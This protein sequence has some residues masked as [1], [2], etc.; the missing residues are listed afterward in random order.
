MKNWMIG[1]KLCW[2]SNEKEITK[3][4]KNTKSK[5]IPNKT[6]NCLW[7][8]EEEHELNACNKNRWQDWGVEKKKV[9]KN[10]LKG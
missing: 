6:M 2:I 7:T 4:E 3:P 1:Q 8:D 9:I 10:Y 5:L